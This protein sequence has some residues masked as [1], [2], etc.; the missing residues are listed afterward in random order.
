MKTITAA[1]AFALS[2]GFYGITAAYASAFNE[3]GVDLVSQVTPT[4]NQT[5]RLADFAHPDLGYKDR[6]AD[7]RNILFSPSG[8]SQKTFCKISTIQ[9]FNEKDYSKQTC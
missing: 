8:S 1:V 2:V 9:G 7:L 4:R 3:R 5:D 6:G